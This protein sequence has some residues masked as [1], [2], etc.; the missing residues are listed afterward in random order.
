[1]L[2]KG[3]FSLTYH[4]FVRKKC[5]PLKLSNLS[6]VLLI[7]KARVSQSIPGSRFRRHF[8]EGQALFYQFARPVS[9]APQQYQPQR[10]LTHP[11]L[12]ICHVT[13]IFLPMSHLTGC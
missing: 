11:S 1:M 7:T 5:S 3:C 12:T 4:F 9:E 10:Y 13:R 8:S 6:F 2:K